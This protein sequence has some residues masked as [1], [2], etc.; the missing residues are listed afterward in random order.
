MKYEC[1]VIRDLMPLC[2]EGMASEASEKTMQA[3]LAECKDCAAEWETYKDGSAPFP[4]TEVPE[5]TK[6]YAKTAKRVQKKHIRALIGVALATVLVIGI[7]VI[8]NAMVICGGRFSA[9]QAAITGLKKN[10]IAD[11]FET[12]WTDHP[13]YENESVCFLQY[14]KANNSQ[15]QMIAVYTFKAGPWWFLGGILDHKEM[16]A[17]PGI[18]AAAHPLGFRYYSGYYYWVNDPT[19]QEITLTCGEETY[20]VQ[21]AQYPDGICPFYPKHGYRA[22]E[23]ELTGTACDADGNVLYTLQGETWVAE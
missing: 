2:A 20:T 22:A 7:G 3:H 12:I 6:Q 1:D 4:E 17:E 16:P 11:R 5:E 10:Q 18:Y 15:P 8:V 9:E 21:T 14:A 19:V 23:G 13:E